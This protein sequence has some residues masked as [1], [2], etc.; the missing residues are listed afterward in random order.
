MADVLIP[1]Y[2]IFFN[3]AG[4]PSDLAG[5]DSKQMPRLEKGDPVML[6]QLAHMMG[7]MTQND[8]EL[9]FSL[10][11]KFASRRRRLRDLRTG[12]PRTEQNKS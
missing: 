11:Q 12:R 7:K 10:A 6:Q 5:L 1:L 4:T 2:Q 8:K 3:T 9:V